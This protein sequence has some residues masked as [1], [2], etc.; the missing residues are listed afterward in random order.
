[1]DIT[2]KKG[3][4]RVKRILP[5]QDAEL[6]LQNI[7]PGKT[8]LRVRGEMEYDRFY[9]DY[10]M[11][12]I[13]LYLAKKKIRPDN[14]EKKRVELHMHTNMSR[15][16]GVSSAHDLIARAMAW[17]H[18]AIAV[19]DHGVTQGYPEALHTAKGI[20]VLYGMEGYFVNDMQD[21][22]C[23][24]GSADEAL[25][26][27]FICFDIESTGTNPNQDAITEIAAVL[28]RNGEICDT[29]QTYTNPGR[30]IPAFIT[31]LTGISDDTVANAVSPA[32]GVRAFRAFCGDRIVVAHNAQFDTS[33]VEK[34]AADDGCP[35]D[36]TFI[37]TLELSRTLMPELPRHKLNVV[38]EGLKLPDFRHH[39][40]SED[41]RVL[42]QIF[43]EF[44][45]RMK[46]MG[47]AR[48]SE[49]NERMS[50][51]RRTN[52]YGGAGLSALPV[53]HII[54]LSLIHI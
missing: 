13:D 47:V 53:R 43:I 37:D 18:T 40:A 44:L 36:M 22:C 54:L 51:L 10:T 45:H 12:P 30:P 8:Y 28:V 23:V 41:T 50:D 5:K 39:S 35:W 32:E 9:E 6:L 25:D 27:E 24:R 1:M 38:A 34:V 17:G 11:K 21:I 26:G 31:E 20:K 46:D 7:D 49:I 19:T 42:A 48:V 29:F 16:D 33:F 2:D 15:M 3:S 14:A 52:V 4:V